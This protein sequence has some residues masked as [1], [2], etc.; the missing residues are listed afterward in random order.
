MDIFGTKPV[1][2]ETQQRIID[3]ATSCVKR[4]GV[5]KTSLNDIAKEA[6]V[7]RPTVYNYFPNRQDILSMALVQSTYD[8]AERLYTHFRKF[9]T[10]RSRLLEAVLFCVETLPNEHSLTLLT[11]SDLS[12]F[13]NEGALTNEFSQQVRLS[14]FKEILK[15]SGLSEAELVELT[16]FATR[17][18]LSLLMTR[19]AIPRDRG[20]LKGFLERRMLP[21]CGL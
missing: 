20:A 2:N 6:G 14:L 18:L 10:P 8:F 17:M 9:K 12:V 5:E 4:W 13:V 21:G 11:G 3:A 7:T 15:D 19:S 1:F 16:E